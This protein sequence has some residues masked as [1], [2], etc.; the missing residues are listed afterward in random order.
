[1]VVG[2]EQVL[3]SLRWCKE[4]SSSLCSK[5]IPNPKSYYRYGDT[6]KPDVWFE[7]SKVW[8]VKA[9]GEHISPVH[10]AA[11]GEVDSDKGISLRFPRLLRIRED[12]APED[13]TS[14]D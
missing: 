8:E 4:R 5:V 13:A 11:V 6:I 1:M 14:S 3:V 2:N 10:R 9:A 7:P 12:K